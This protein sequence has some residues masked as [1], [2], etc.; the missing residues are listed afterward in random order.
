MEAVVRRVR[1][2]RPVRIVPDEGHG[3]V[4]VGSVTWQRWQSARVASALTGGWAAGSAVAAWHSVQ[5]RGRGAS[6]ATAFAGAPFGKWQATV[7]VGGAVAVRTTSV[8]P[9]VVVP[10]VNVYGTSKPKVA[11]SG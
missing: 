1:G 5:A 7:Q 3:A 8:P 4:H 6:H 11:P 2:A 10:P 9:A